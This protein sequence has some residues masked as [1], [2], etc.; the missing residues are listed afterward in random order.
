VPKRVV[1][2]AQAKQQPESPMPNCT[3]ETI[4]LGKVGRRTIEASFD[5]GAIS[6]DAGVLLL[7]QADERVGLTRAVAKA[8]GDG[9][10]AAGWSNA[11]LGGP[12][13][14]ADWRGIMSASRKLWQV[15]TTSPLFASCSA[16]PFPC[17]L[18]L[19]NRL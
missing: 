6:S 12:H 17:S 10:R 1:I 3:V 11:A 7:R 19:Y 8:F 9:R 4:A 16:K 15:C 5:G 18:Q 13:D 2:G 14:F